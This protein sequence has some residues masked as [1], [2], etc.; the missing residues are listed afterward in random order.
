MQMALSE[1]ARATTREESRFRIDYPNSRPRRSRIIALDDAGLATLQELDGHQWSD[2]RFLRFVARKAVDESLQMLA[3]DAVLEDNSGRQVSLIE[4]IENA[5]VIIMVITAGS[6]ASA[7]EII[8]N[9]AFVRN[10]LTTGLV[11][12]TGAVSSDEMSLTL[13]ALRPFAPMLVIS[14]GSEYVDAMLTALRV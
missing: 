7:A 11:L 8:A 13:K 14:S 12:N 2:A 1:S 5:D 3:F 6:D 9:A 10:K 4:E